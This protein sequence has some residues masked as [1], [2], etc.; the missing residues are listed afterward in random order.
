MRAALAQALK[1]YAWD[2]ELIRL[3]VTLMDLA[4]LQP[5]QLS[6]FDF[7]DASPSTTP[8]AKPPPEGGKPPPGGGKPVAP[9]VRLVEALRLRH[10]GAF[11]QAQVTD[12]QHAVR[13]R[14]FQWTAL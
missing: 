11:F 3:S 9:F 14:R 7:D 12:A 2:A 13:E 10:A 4:E 8:S 5:A 6:L 1:T